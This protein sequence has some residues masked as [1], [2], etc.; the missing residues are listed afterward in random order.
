MT[1]ITIPVDPDSATA[2]ASAPPA[3]RR[4]LELLL[5]LRLKELVT[6]EPRSLQTIMDE[7]GAEAEAKGLT[8]DVL[9]ELL[10]EP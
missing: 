9:E 10:R 8:P 4:K 3:E 2:F 1:T 6:R 5:R 7:I